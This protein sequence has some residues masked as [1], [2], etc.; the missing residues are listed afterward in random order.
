M[1]NINRQGLE[2]RELPQDEEED[3]P[4]ALELLVGVYASCRLS[5][6]CKRQGADMTAV[7]LPVT[8]VEEGEGGDSAI[9]VLE[10]VALCL[11]SRRKAAGVQHATCL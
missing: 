8:R 1:G 4:G 5:P 7:P 3:L 10:V 9:C 11:V 6:A 2:G